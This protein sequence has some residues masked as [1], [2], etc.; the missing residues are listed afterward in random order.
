MTSYLRI[1]MY[2]SRLYLNNEGLSYSIHV[3]ERISC[4]FC[5]IVNTK[6]Y[7]SGFKGRVKTDIYRWC[8]TIY[9]T[10]PP[11]GALIYY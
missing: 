1:I 10:I 2:P 11:V 5:K 4:T 3:M 6:I 8:A 7:V 9:A